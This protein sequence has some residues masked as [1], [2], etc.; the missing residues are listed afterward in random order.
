MALKEQFFA[1]SGLLNCFQETKNLS[2]EFPQLLDEVIL[3]N[4]KLVLD[5][6]LPFPPKFNE[7]LLLAL[8]G[9][10][11]SLGYTLPVWS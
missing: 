7:Q 1:V 5:H 2:E 9:G 11:T 4:K 6:I 3:D 10:G 8:V